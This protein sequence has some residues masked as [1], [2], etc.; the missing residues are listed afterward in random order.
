MAV[1]E[2]TRR[3]ATVSAPDISADVGC[4]VGAI[5][6]T[7]GAFDGAIRLRRDDVD[8]AGQSLR[9]IERGGRTADDL[10]AF[11]VIQRHAIEFKRSGGASDQTYPVDQDRCVL[12]AEPLHLDARA[13]IVVEHEAGLFGQY[14]GQARS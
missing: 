11:D 2:K 4:F 13:V 8:D 10:D 6:R 14:L 3:S 1:D 7:D 5:A 9:P 12:G